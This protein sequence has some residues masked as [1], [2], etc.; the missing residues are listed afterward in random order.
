MERLWGNIGK[1]YFDV[2]SNLGGKDVEHGPY[3]RTYGNG[4]YIFTPDYSPE[5]C[6]HSLT[7]STNLLCVGQDPKAAG[8]FAKSPGILAEAVYYVRSPYIISDAEFSGNFT[9]K[10]PGDSI[11]V[12]IS[13]D[14]ENW[15]QVYKA[16]KLGSF[17]IREH[18][19]AESFNVRKKYPP[20]L[21]TPFGHYEYLVKI[22][23]YAQ[24]DITDSAVR[25]FSLKT[26]VQLNQ[27]SMPQL[28]PGRNKITVE[29]DISNDTSLVVTYVWNDL[30]GSDKRNSVLVTGTPFSYEIL[31]EAD[32]WKDIV[33]KKI[34]I[35]A[36]PKQPGEGRFLE[37]EKPPRSINT[38]SPADAFE[39]F[40]LIGSNYPSDLKT[41][42]QYIDDLNNAIAA[43]EGYPTDSPKVYRQADTVKSALLGISAHG[44]KAYSAK[45]AV[46]N[47]IKKDRSS[48]NNKAYACQTIYQI[49]GYEAVPILQK[50]LQRDVS[51]M[52]ADDSSISTSA[53]L[54]INTASA[55]SSVLGY[56]AMM[57]IDEARTAADDVQLLLDESWVQN[58][59]GFKPGKISRW[60]ER[61][62]GFV[63]SLGRL[64][65]AKQSTIL[66]NII[67]GNFNGDEKAVAA[68]SLGNLGDPSSLGALKKLLVKHQYAPQ[69]WYAIESIGKIGSKNDAEFLYPF[70]NHWDE[71]YRGY[72]A[73]ALGKLGNPD[74]IPE[75]R[76]LLENE[77]F[78]WVIE[79]AQKSLKELDSK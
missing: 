45:D 29:G 31:T 70:L 44:G 77:Q 6:K 23:L 43:Q 15:K 51:I 50:V 69:G 76:A 36:I 42:E 9:R 26:I 2:W 78:P 7:S 18:N 75:L 60:Q 5:N 27:F 58:K 47:A 22:E 20:G 52:W 54:W 68:K 53:N 48:P 34:T 17:T 30:T 41:V 62:W 49:S 35:E 61:K 59:S 63:R 33:V 16:D 55:A 37:Q 65:N 72:T 8:I 10:N 3:M 57:G 40:S 14:G 67:E 66:T 64:G 71:N 74:A 25:D 39:T 73:E 38:I 32:V 56:M 1:P 4:I 28:W 11:K 13:N 24:N 19:I 21:I 79:A 46:L 12:F